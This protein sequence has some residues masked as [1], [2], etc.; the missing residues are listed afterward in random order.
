LAK[1]VSG[2]RGDGHIIKDETDA[3]LQNKSK[4][5]SPAPLCTSTFRSLAP[6]FLAI[7]TCFISYLPG[8]KAGILQTQAHLYPDGEKSPNWKSP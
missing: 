5:S 3:I 2:G 8:E 6:R 7:F 1:A 4:Y